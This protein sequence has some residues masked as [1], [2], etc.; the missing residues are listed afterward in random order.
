MALTC[1]GFHPGRMTHHPPTWNTFCPP[2]VDVAATPK[3][4]Q[5]ERQVT[6]IIGYCL[7]SVIAL[8]IIF[9]GARFAF[10]PHAAAAA[11]SAITVP[12]PWG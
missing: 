2:K 7:S 12:P 6:D 11:A 5:R 1:R 4:E 8:G 9:I 3:G 10:A